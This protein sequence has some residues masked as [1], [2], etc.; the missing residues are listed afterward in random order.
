M[1]GMN[2][3][4]SPPPQTTP[5]ISSVIQV[6]YLKLPATADWTVRIVAAM[7]LLSGLV[8]VI[9][10]LLVRVSEHPKLFSL[11]VP[12]YLYHWS[13]SLTVGFG[14]LLILLSVN[15]L[16]RKRMAWLVAFVISLGSIALQLARVGSEH[17]KWIA[18]LDLSAA[19][20]AYSLAPSAV[21]LI[22]L[23]LTRN[24]FT[25]A[26][27]RI[28]LKEGVLKFVACLLV[29]VIYGTI[30]FWLLDQ[31]DF[32][33]DFTLKQSV[34][35]TLNELTMSGNEDLKPHTRIGEWFLDSLHFSGCLLAVLAVYSLFRPVRYSLETL[36]HERILTKTLLENNGNNSL[37]FFKLLP[38]KSYFFSHSGN[39][40][41]AYKTTMNVAI[42]LGDTVGP[43]EELLDTT[44]GWIEFCHNNGWSVAF[45]QTAPDLLDIYKKLGLAVVKVG[46]DAVVDLNQFCQKTVLKKSFKSVLKKYEKEGYSLK[47]FAPPHSADLIDEI[48]EVSHE[49]LSLPGRRERGFSLGKFDRHEIQDHVLF[50]V[51]AKDSRII[52]FVD[53]I[54]D[55][56]KGEATIDM[57]RHRVEVPGGTMDFLFAKLLPTLKEEGYAQFSLGLAALSGVGETPDASM[58]ERAMHQIYEHMNRFFSY[59]GLRQYKS[60][61]EPTWEERFL[62]YEGGPPGLIKTAIALAHATEE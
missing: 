30:G 14:L 12:Y 28:T 48:E 36:P 17:I 35:R 5:P 23:W 6:A 38:D 29:A 58:E 61:F 37:D 27:E 13:R 34:K 51:C 26:S 56:R 10:P 44:R 25:V 55:Y 49:W 32:G 52:A 7:T 39:A 4:S 54:T 47:R 21:S 46:E 50:A 42:S 40:V 62:V 59:K 20:P 33:I 11:V 24:H 19:I 15:L 18:D 31:R 60:K 3:E 41:I 57:M 45:L 43:K 2:P 9:Q 22:L 53:Q 1:S 8:G 16:R